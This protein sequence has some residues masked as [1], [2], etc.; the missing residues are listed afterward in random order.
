M[1]R[2]KITWETH[3]K[4]Y[5]TQR[6]IGC[7]RK[8]GSQ[9]DLGS[10]TEVKG[11]FEDIL[12]RVKDG[13]MPKNGRPWSDAQVADFEQWKADGFL[14]FSP[15]E[16][17]LTDVRVIGPQ[18]FKVKGVVARYGID[19]EYVICL[20]KETIEENNLLRLWDLDGNTEEYIEETYD[21]ESNLGIDLTEGTYIMCIGV[22]EYNG[23]G[24]L[25]PF[26]LVA[27]YEYNTNTS[28]WMS[29]KVNQPDSFGIW[30]S[31]IPRAIFDYN[32]H[33]NI[34]SYFVQRNGYVDTS[35]VNETLAQQDI[36]FP[37]EI[38]QIPRPHKSGEQYNVTICV[39]SVETIACGQDY[40]PD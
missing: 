37:D 11:K 4:H 17:K 23:F 39:G 2:D 36:Q 21:I 7:M 15:K 12:S 8:N 19:N 24:G 16:T 9:F 28:D 13:S 38:C 25:T 18:K 29:L 3:V 22:R 30:R 27:S 40:N 6:D 32:K 14:F 31:D 35:P 10:Y 34:E 26:G 1:S 5:F 20:F 33:K